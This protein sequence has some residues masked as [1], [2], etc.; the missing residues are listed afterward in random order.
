MSQ[1][2]GNANTARPRKPRRPRA[3]QACQ[4]CRS[5]KYKCSGTFPCNH[6]EKY[7]RECTF[8]SSQVGVV[9]PHVAS[10]VESLEKQVKDLTA[11]LAS[12]EDLPYPSP[13]VEKVSTERLGTEVS[14]LS[15]SSNSPNDLS[16]ATASNSERLND[17]STAEITDVNQ[18][19]KGIEFHGSSSSFA[20]LRRVR[21]K[22]L[23]ERQGHSS[24][25][26]HPPEMSSL[27]SVLHNPSFSPQDSSLCSEDVPLARL[28]PLFSPRVCVFLD[29]YFNTLHYIHPILDK[30]SIYRRA[31]HIWAGNLD[32]VS[33]SF[34][35]LYLSIVSMGALIRTWNEGEIAGMHRFGWSRKAFR[36]ASAR[37]EKMS[38][39]NDIETIH[40]FFIMAKICQNELNPNLSYMY[41][42]LAI[43]VGLSAGINRATSLS[44]G[45]DEVPSDLII[46]R[47]WW[48]AYSLEIELSF[49]LG[50]PDTLGFDNFHN[51]SLPPADDTEFAI[52]PVMVEF[53][54]II[55]NVSADI[56][57]SQVGPQERLLRAFELQAN[58]KSWLD[59]LP[60]QIR[61][62]MPLDTR[63]SG[64][65][66]DPSWARMQRLVLQ[67]RFYNVTMLLLRPFLV[68]ASQ[69]DR[70]AVA[71][72]DEA[73]TDCINAAAHTVDVVFETLNVH[74]Y[75]RTWW[76]NTTYILFAASIF[77]F[78]LAQPPTGIPVPWLVELVERSIDILQ[79]M[80]E[81]IV[82]Q[83]AVDM[84]KQTLIHVRGGSRYSGNAAETVATVGTGTNAADDAGDNFTTELEGLFGVGDMDFVSAFSSY[85]VPSDF[86]LWPHS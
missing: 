76:Y 64:G 39:T 44:H 68:Y 2:D 55:R 70:P 53:A 46:S 69:R 71:R 50:R 66:R 19:T 34:I 31:E 21:Q 26:F 6:C 74:T 3:P 40:T 80:E 27:V 60:P 43:R 77:L 12:K 86:M 84:I 4:F 79:S 51:R 56:Y 82:A 5:K 7:A 49:A 45:N 61:P 23:G 29:S 28:D 62:V 57:L 14:S 83:K 18:H 78:A 25:E 67:I 24:G 85:A 63:R 48:G 65:L 42:G 81:C 20:F 58:M 52:L 9:T 35:A 37:L 10:Y 15:A 30:E 33:R 38:L 17:E 32:H 73:V 59:Q 22:I 36:A 16:A 13:T 75:F 8:D 1:D 54:R 47:T 72:L 41:L 11:A